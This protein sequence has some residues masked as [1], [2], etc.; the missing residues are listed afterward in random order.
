MAKF[1]DECEADGPIKVSDA[2]FG[3][4]VGPECLFSTTVGNPGKVIAYRDVTSL[5]PKT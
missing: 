4:R 2:F 5:Y 1:F 3:G